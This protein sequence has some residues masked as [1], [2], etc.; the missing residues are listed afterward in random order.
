MTVTFLTFVMFS[1][2]TL[3]KV[4]AVNFVAGVIR[5]HD[6][7]L[8]RTEN[9]TKSDNLTSFHAG[10][11]LD[12]KISLQR[13]T[14]KVVISHNRYNKNDHLNFTSKA[15]EAA[16]HWALTP[17]LTGKLSAD[18]TEKLNDFNDTRNTSRNVRVTQNQQFLADFNPGGGWHY[19]AGLSRKSLKNSNTFN[20]DASFSANAV[21]FGVKYVFPST[22]SITFMNHARKGKYDD[23]KINQA[24]LFDDKYKEYESALALDWLLTVKS[25]VNVGASYL[26]REHDNF[27]K[28]DY[29]GLQGHINYDW[30]PT[31][32]IK[33]GLNAKS[34]LSTYQTDVDS[35]TRK[36]EL[37]LKPTYALTPKVRIKGHLDVS[38]RKFLGSGYNAATSSS[39]VDGY[40]SAGIG[41]EWRPTRQSSVELSWLRYDLNSNNNAFDY[42]GNVAALSGKIEF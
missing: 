36:N 12:K 26:K 13:V 40:K 32:R 41:V 9:N 34:I 33:V 6:D 11:K 5:K 27:S 2:E 28:R 10:L 38:E 16:W 29:S 42:K 30:Q 24:L 3:A 7:N 25:R 8:F 15:F 4:K 37:A 21:D 23:R 39:R 22:S 20:E 19:L 31:K 17:R 18:R 1:Q 14:A 35:Y